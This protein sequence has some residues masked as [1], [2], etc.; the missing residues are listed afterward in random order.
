MLW[1]RLAEGNEEHKENTNHEWAPKAHLLGKHRPAETQS[2]GLSNLVHPE[3]LLL[4]P[5]FTELASSHTNS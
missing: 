2:L 3:E 5:I 4:F 1:E